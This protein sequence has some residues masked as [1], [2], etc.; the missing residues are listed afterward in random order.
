[1][2]SNM[3]SIK[4]S[5]PQSTG[6]QKLTALATIYSAARL[7]SLAKSNQELLA[8]QQQSNLILRNI[9]DEL[10]KLNGLTKSLKALQSST[11]NELQKK[12][13]R[14]RI[15]DQIT[16][17]RYHLEELRRE[18]ERLESNELQHCKDSVHSL[19]R[20]AKLLLRSEYTD[21]EKLFLLEAMRESLSMLT[22]IKFKEISDKQYLA[23]TEDLIRQAYAELKSKLSKQDIRDYQYCL[24]ISQ[25]ALVDELAEMA[26]QAVKLK[27][28]M[29]AIDSIEK[30]IETKTLLSDKQYS[31][32]MKQLSVIG[33]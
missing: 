28:K 16:D 7:N 1:M 14:D 2:A 18:Q 27:K 11:L 19:N 33:I 10:L 21:V 12:N 30:L 24:E 9:D 22:D 25:E 29:D 20:E 15:R 31:D 17:Y 6:A 13:E 4:E 23:E 5:K 3:A 26:K 32:A 8:A